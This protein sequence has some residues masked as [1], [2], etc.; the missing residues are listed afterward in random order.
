V[1]GLGNAWRYRSSGRVVP[2]ISGIHSVTVK[3]GRVP[4][5]LEFSVRGENGSYPVSLGELP[6]RST[7]VVD[8]PA[9]GTGQCGEVTFGPLSCAFDRFSLRWWSRRLSGCPG[10]VHGI[11]GTWLG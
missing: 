3:A 8:S 6:H 7:F 4:G 11:G 1:K 10:A 9:A 5:Q 2:L